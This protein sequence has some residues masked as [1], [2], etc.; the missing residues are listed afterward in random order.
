M[1]RTVFGFAYY[2]NF[3]F[4]DGSGFEFCSQNSEIKFYYIHFRDYYVHNDGSSG[5]YLDITIPHVTFRGNLTDM[6]PQH[7]NAINEIIEHHF[8]W[9]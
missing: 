5:W 4:D 9:V 7:T 3:I 6:L 8:T 1:D 2:I